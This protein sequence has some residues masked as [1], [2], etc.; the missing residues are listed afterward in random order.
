MHENNLFEKPNP[1]ETETEKL[2]GKVYGSVKELYDEQMALSMSSSPIKP[3]FLKIYGLRI[4]K[5]P[6]SG[7]GL[8]FNLVD[9]PN[10]YSK[11]RP[12]RSNEYHFNLNF[13]ENDKLVACM[14][15]DNQNISRY[16]I[17]ICQ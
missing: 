17:E 13:Y 15:L 5:G 11:A 8:D 3:T 12:H 10:S 14:H 9:D 7:K 2:K 4:E 1:A 16:R 6:S